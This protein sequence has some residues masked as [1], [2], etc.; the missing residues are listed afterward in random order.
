MSRKPAAW[1]GLQ[2]HHFEIPLGFFVFVKGEVTVTPVK[3][4]CE[5]LTMAA[6]SNHRA[7]GSLSFDAGAETRWAHSRSLR[8]INVKVKIG[9]DF[10]V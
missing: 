5:G 10:G 8:W 1:G 7:V 3:A 9:N 2:G 4:I 6:D